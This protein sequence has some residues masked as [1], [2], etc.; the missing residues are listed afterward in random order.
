MFFW[1]CSCNEWEMLN[2]LL[3]ITIYFKERRIFV[4]ETENTDYEIFFYR[5]R[6]QPSG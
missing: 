4:T 5:S 3:Y 1:G 6:L 2:K